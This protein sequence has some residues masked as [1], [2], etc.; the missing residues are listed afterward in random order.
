MINFK[1]NL[2]WTEIFQ[3]VFY[4]LYSLYYNSLATGVISMFPV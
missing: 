1:K 3:M 2:L 4:T